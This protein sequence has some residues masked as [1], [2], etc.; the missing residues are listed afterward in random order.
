MPL[1]FLLRFVIVQLESVI[2]LGD[3]AFRLWGKGKAMCTPLPFTFYP[4]RYRRSLDCKESL[5]PWISLLP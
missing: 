1:K 2:P 4:E 5:L 3:W